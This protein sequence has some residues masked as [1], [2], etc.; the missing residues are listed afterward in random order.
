MIRF[1]LKEMLSDKAFREGKRVNLDELSGATGV[2]KSTLSR[3]SSVRGYNTTTDNIDK[4]C[5]YF[6]CS[7]EKLLEYVPDEEVAGLEKPDKTS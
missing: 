1:K 3:I 7:V 6:G 2:N 4:L 5:R